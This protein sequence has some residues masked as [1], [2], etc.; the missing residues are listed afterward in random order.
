MPKTKH[1]WIDQLLVIDVSNSG[2]LKKYSLL[3][4]KF[5]ILLVREFGRDRCYEKSAAL[6]FVSL[7]GI[8]PLIAIYLFFIPIFF[9]TEEL[10]VN[11]TKFIIENLI[12]VQDT[13]NIMGMTI[14]Q[15][16]SAFKDNAG[17]VGIFGIVGLLVAGIS[18]FIT[19][20]KSYNAVWHIDRRRNFIKSL[21]VFSG[22][23]LWIPVLI[24]LSF[25]LSAELMTKN[26]TFGVRL[27]ML[28]PFLMGFVG[29]AFSY[30]FVPNTKVN[31]K[32]ALLAAFISAIL[33]E[34][35]KSNFGYWIK[36]PP[37]MN[38][39][40]KTLG[41]IPIFII[42]LYFVWVI[43]LLGTEI[44]YT[45]QNFSRLL[46]Q[47]LRN[48][49]LRVDFISVIAPLFLIAE[50]FNKGKGDI[51]F[52]EIRTKIFIDPYT[53]AKALD[54]LVESGFINFNES[55]DSYI[56]SL[57]PD[58]IYLH[59]LINL[60][61]EFNYIFPN[62]EKCGKTLNDFINN[63]DSAIAEKINNKSLKE[64]MND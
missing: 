21:T 3:F 19:I 45:F 57:P 40:A 12:P 16:F 13:D 18:L 61:K 39:F 43:I 31:I 9:N 26:A 52:E 55:E 44:S 17:K 59:E 1:A 10:Q 2:F 29:L 41:I 24:G 32:S 37:V 54:R 62:K 28:L 27:Q 58:K 6:T 56:L 23:I 5:I 25:Y 22:V 64:I 8:F 48:I 42:W 4:I 11:I 7:L 47:V 63:L 36:K 35:A 60:N 38:N 50:N 15:T 49:N 46:S 34:L 30:V 33:W 14:Q 53:L 20:E 51:S